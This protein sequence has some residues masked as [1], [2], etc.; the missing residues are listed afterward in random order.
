MVIVEIIC[1]LSVGEVD[2]RTDWTPQA[3]ISHDQYWQRWTTN[4]QCPSDKINIGE[5][6]GGRGGE[7]KWN[8]E[9]KLNC[10][11]LSDDEYS[12][13]FLSENI[14]NFPFA[15]FILLSISGTIFYRPQINGSEAIIHQTGRAG[16]YIGWW[17]GGM[18]SWRDRN[19]TNSDC[20]N[21]WMTLWA[22][23]IV[24][25]IVYDWTLNIQMKEFMSD[26]SYASLCLLHPHKITWSLRRRL[27]MTSPPRL[28]CVDWIVTVSL[29][30]IH[31]MDN[32]WWQFCLLRNLCHSTDHIRR[33]HLLLLLF[34]LFVLLFV[35]HTQHTRTRIMKVENVH[36]IS[37]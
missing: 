23:F 20:T 1:S 4:I 13:N 26:I 24:V 19:S 15:N 29:L 5:T 33:L 32:I 31:F 22:E 14:A 12:F 21:E 34:A 35:V 25:V 9:R 7:V 2:D 36:K 30:L 28:H 16:T 27:Q 11:G 3:G 17:A 10:P 18:K 8:D 6:R 37:V